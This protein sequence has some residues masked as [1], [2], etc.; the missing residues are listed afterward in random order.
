MEFIQFGLKLLNQPKLDFLRISDFNT[1]GLEG[2]KEG[3]IGTPWSS[4]VK[5]SGSSNKGDSSG[6]SFGIGKSAPFL[7][8]KLRTLFYASFDEAGYQSYIGVSNIMSYITPDKKTTL[9]NGYYTRNLDSQAISGE[10]FLDDSFNRKETGTDVYVSAFYPQ[11]EWEKEMKESVLHNF[12]IPVFNNELIVN[13]NGFEINNQNIG[14][15][16]EDLNNNFEKNRIL[17]KYFS[18]LTSDQVVRLKYPAKNYK[19]RISFEEG[20]AELLL[21]KGDD[22]NRRVLMTRKTG[23]RL[24]EQK[25]ISGSISFSGLLRI[26]G[27]NMNVIFKDME[28]P[29]HTEWTPNRYEKDPKLANEVYADLRE[30]IRDTVKDLFQETVTDEMDAVGLSDFLPNTNLMDDEGNEERESL[31]ARVKSLVTKKKTLKK[32]VAKKSTR[33][34][35]EV[36]DIEKQLAGDFG[37]TEGETGGNGEGQHGEGGGDAGAGLTDSDGVKDMD[38][39][40]D[41]NK[42]AKPESVKKKKAIVVTQKYICLDKKKGKYKFIIFP[43]MAIS[44]GELAFRVHGEQSDF[45]IPI[46]AATSSDIEIKNYTSNIVTFQ[47]TNRKKQLIL[48]VE[49][50]YDDYC[51]L[52]VDL[53]EN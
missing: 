4:L 5:E 6:G 3:G 29:A 45:D 9:G 20:E 13:I 23:M 12:F 47:T 46:K 17:K 14:Q 26:T 34:G 38:K 25:N 48:N 18:L 36:A 27:N 31:N 1:K 19:G 37:I 51:V 32:K 49:I 39:N 52:A 2:A 28:N 10:L 24:F 40:G 16:I 50:D 42:D 8:S 11:E 15:L 44:K 22:L 53:Y 21:L 35:E 30:F 43:E 41:G 7:N 33:K